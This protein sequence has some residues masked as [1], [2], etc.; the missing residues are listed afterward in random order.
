MT[1]LE[2]LEELRAAYEAA[3]GAAV[4]AEAD[5]YAAWDTADTA[6]RDAAVDAAL[7]D[8][9]AAVAAYYDADYAYEAELNK[10]Q[11]ENSND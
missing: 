2:E 6:A 8:Y 5:C 11:K 7:I 1:K 3:A 10:T 4:A 9:E